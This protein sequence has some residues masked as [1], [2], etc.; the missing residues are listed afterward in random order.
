M[1]KASNFPTHTI[2][3]SICVPRDFY[4]KQNFHNSTNRVFVIMGLTEN[5]SS[6]TKANLSLLVVRNIKCSVFEPE[7]K[8]YKYLP[9]WFKWLN[10]CLLCLFIFP[11]PSVCAISYPVLV[12]VS[13]RWCNHYESP[14]SQV[15]SNR[16]VE[17]PLFNLP[18]YLYCNHY[19]LLLLKVKGHCCW[20]ALR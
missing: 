17:K 14:L 18:H 9:L 10:F 19:I 20:S 8:R 15:R 16:E 2:Y 7:N 3:L 12:I 6:I 11:Y 5:S 13:Y 1:H 4:S